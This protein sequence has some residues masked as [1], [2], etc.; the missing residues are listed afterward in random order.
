MSEIV[1]TGE[2]DEEVLEFTDGSMNFIDVHTD[3]VPIR[4]YGQI[5][6]W[7]TLMWYDAYPGDT[8]IESETGG[9]YVIP[10][11]VTFYGRRD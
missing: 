2:N 7:Q 10:I 8:I 4:R 5:Y 9:F 11:R 6:N 1:W 3:D